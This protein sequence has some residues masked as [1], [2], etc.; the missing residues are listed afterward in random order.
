MVQWEQIGL[1]R[2]SE[3]P[4]YQQVCD[5]IRGLI[6]SGRLASG[7]KLPPS[8]ELSVK[9]GINRNTAT[10]AYEELAKTGEVRSHVGQGTFVL[11]AAESSASPMRFRF[12][13]AVENSAGRVR[14][15]GAFRSGHPDPIDFATLVPD[16]DLFPI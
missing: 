3:V 12:S 2:G 7:D 4:L 15:P 6:V 11:G 8:R 16:E 13:R 1:D 10:S 14:T 5:A 9:L